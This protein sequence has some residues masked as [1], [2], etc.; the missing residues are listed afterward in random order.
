MKWEYSLPI[1]RKYLNCSLGVDS[2]ECDIQE[3][4]TK[5]ATNGPSLNIYQGR[6][7]CSTPTALFLAQKTSQANHSQV[8]NNGNCN[9]QTIIY[10]Q[11]PI[12]N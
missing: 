1:P 2:E 4:D 5:T 6:R 11:K 7:T 9:I 3:I 10:S 12:T 8:Q